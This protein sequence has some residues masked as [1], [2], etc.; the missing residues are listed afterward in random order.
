[1]WYWRRMEKISWTDHVRNEGVLL[2]VKQQ[3]N[4][5]H[6]IRKRKAN[7]IGHILRRNCLPQGVTEGKIQGGIEVTGRQGRRRRK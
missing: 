7:W 3:R 6:E 2:R 1:M 4:I 5:L